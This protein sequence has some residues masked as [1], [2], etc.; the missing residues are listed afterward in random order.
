MESFGLIDSIN[1]IS[2]N[3]KDENLITQIST[4]IDK[5]NEENKTVN[6]YAIQL[7]NIGAISTK[8]TFRLDKNS[9][10]LSKLPSILSHLITTFSASI[11]QISDAQLNFNEII[12]ENS[13]T[14]FSQLYSIIY[15]HYKRK[16][17]LQLYKIIGGIDIIGNPIKL[18][19]SIGTG[20]YSLFNEPRKEF[21]KGPKNFG[22]GIGKG[23]KSLFSG[24]VGGT[25]DSASKIT[26]GLL[27]ATKMIQGESN[28]NNIN[29]K[30]EEEPKGFFGGAFSG[31]KKGFNE[32]TKGVTGIVTKPIEGSKKEGIGGFFKGI[33]K[34]V[35]GAALTP[36]NTVLTVGNE[37]TKG[38]SNSKLISNKVDYF[39]FRE[40]RILSD[41]LPIDNY[42]IMEHRNSQNIFIKDNNGNDVEISV[43]NQFLKL[44]NSKK[45]LEKCFLDGNFYVI[46]SDVLVVQLKDFC[47]CVFK[48]YLDDVKDVSLGNEGKKFRLKVNLFNGVS[49]FIDFNNGNDGEKILKSIKKVLKK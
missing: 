10:H 31:F 5:L 25:A 19:D 16:L 40:P 41:N 46:V 21:L 33:G 36:V 6:Y 15:D 47:D 22:R 39:R 44:E 20:F 42:D 32:I 49:K 45:I 26:G 37:T 13:Y 12:L 7:L 14:N 28:D 48:V 34:G 8:I 43:Q 29:I 18:F 38:I 17:I 27:N 3:S 30:K 35:M 24:I 2:K 9:I 23:V 4:S 11:S 1:T